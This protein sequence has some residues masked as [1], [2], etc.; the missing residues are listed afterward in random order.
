[1]LLPRLRHAQCF[2]TSHH[3]GKYWASTPRTPLSCTDTAHSYPG[4]IF[5]GV[6]VHTAEFAGCG[7]GA[8]GT[9]RQGTH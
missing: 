4:V 7:L 5:R 8:Y 6:S 3:P 2:I 1:M 9:P